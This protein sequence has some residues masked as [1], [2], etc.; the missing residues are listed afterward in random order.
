MEM[1]GCWAREEP[2]KG[3]LSY[4]QECDIKEDIANFQRLIFVPI[5]QQRTCQ[6]EF[7]QELTN[8]LLFG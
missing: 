3:N 6:V 4:W 8:I 5:Q 7:S 2:K 1:H